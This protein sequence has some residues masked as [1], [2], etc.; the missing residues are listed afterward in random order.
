M[1]A[2]GLA[3]AGAAETKPA[4]T[5]YREA[6]SYGTLRDTD[7]PRYVRTLADVWDDAP[8]GSHC[9]D[10]GLDFRF[11]YEYRDDDLRRDSP[12]L[13]Q[14]LL[15][16]TRVYFGVKEKWDPFRFAVE[17]EDA[18]RYHS[19]YERDDR[20][21]NEFEPIQIYAEL[22]FD[23][24]LGRDPLGNAR[25]LSLRAGRMAF[26]FLDRRLLAN[27]QW[28]N[29][30]NTFQGFR[31]ALGQDSNDWQVDLLAVQPLRR[32]KYDLDEPASGEWLY[33]AIGHW[34]GWPDVIVL[35]P[36]FLSLNQP[37]RAIHS[38]ALRGY[39]RLGP[40]G[41]DYDFDAVWQFGDDA[42]RR[43]RAWALSTEV[44]HAWDAP[45]RPRLS[46][47]YA[48]ASGDGDPDDDRSG[49]FERYF[50]FNRP[51][52]ASDYILWENVSVPRLRLE[53]QPA[54][55]LRLDLS[56][57][58]YWLASASDRWVVA[59]L[60]DP[61]SASGDFIGQEFD[62][63]LRWKLN[64]CVDVT[65]GYAHFEPGSFP[66][67]NGKPWDSDFAYLEISLNAL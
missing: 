20:D 39:G 51:L 49:R 12:G 47:A 41:F 57:A 38:T 30:T 66:R 9:F 43:H 64:R 33:A 22:H 44:G 40:T 31:V 25:P 59:D 5:Y 17:L 3:F 63:R 4:G 1:A 27:N 23:E 6:P 14:P 16:R 48:Y 62:F 50:G 7:P 52:S 65:L 58:F 29:T 56:Y 24:A 26:E 35:E 36:Y 19:P 11:R 45:W 37:G 21:V 2:C 53:A 8:A 54:K 13:I 15:Y 67:N 28:R 18:R 60:R 34:R 46:F 42:G 61:E 10:I 55:N 32:L